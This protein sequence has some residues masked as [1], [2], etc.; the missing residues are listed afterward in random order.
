MDQADL[1]FP[2][3][4]GHVAKGTVAAACQ[5]GRFSKPCKFRTYSNAWVGAVAL[6]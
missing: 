2:E 4:V 6:Y 5:S 1:P 3:P